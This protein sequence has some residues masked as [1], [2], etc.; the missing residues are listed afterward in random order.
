MLHPTGHSTRV[1]GGYDFLPMGRQPQ[2]GAVGAWERD[3]EQ[4]MW[5]ASYKY[6]WRKMEAAAQNRA[7]G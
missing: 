1:K 2:A 6:S 5:T 3:L 7:E 4:E